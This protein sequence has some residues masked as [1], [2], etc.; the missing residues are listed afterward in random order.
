MKNDNSQKKASKPWLRLAE[1]VLQIVLAFILFLQVNYLSCRRNEAWDLSR[2][3]R[4]TLSPATE[5]VIGQI[6]EPITLVLAFLSS[7]PIYEEVR[8]L[9]AEYDR[10][11]KGQVH[12]ES[13]DLSRS[14]DRM[15]ELES[16]YGVKF[17]GDQ[18]LVL[19]PENRF[20]VLRSEDLLI[21]ETADG[22][23]SQFVGEERVSSSILELIEGRERR[24]AL[25]AGD[26]PSDEL[27]AVAS[28]LIPFIEAQNGRL[29]T[30][31]LEDKQ[32]IPADLD[33]L[34]I[35]GNTTDLTDREAA[36]L[37]QS[38][39]RSQFGV[40]C[41]LDP[42]AT[43]PN[44]DGFLRSVGLG[45]RRDRVLSVVEIPGMA[46][47]KS[48]EVPVVLLPSEAVTK[49]MGAMTTR[50]TGLTRSIN[51]L[52]EDDLLLAENI[53][54]IPLAAASEGFWGETE[55]Q[56]EQLSY[57]PD[58][59]TGAPDLVFVAGA[60]ERGLPGD[61]NLERGASRMV[62]MGNSEVISAESPSQ[63]V[64]ADF[65]VSSMNWVMKRGDGLG[66]PPR[67]RVEFS[68]PLSGA[69]F[70]RLQIWI[71]FVFPAAFLAVAAL[72]LWRRRR[73]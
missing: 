1:V 4:F 41:A 36:L 37:E 64:A 5:Q 51:V 73:W 61:A 63:Q 71:L 15:L 27:A 20:K 28:R 8:A 6:G 32:R 67:S 55:Y 68:L 69:D 14:R 39:I 56:E 34:L 66:L 65:F 9:A 29:E 42:G 30:L 25:L 33:C 17:N 58:R 35:L 24:I 3:Q 43:T 50:F 60:V 10:L 38:W 70:G 21:S 22:R 72:V 53:R 57:N 46:A 31:N 19:G 11:G 49:D 23:I 26:R 54:P 2:D 59:D 52:F 44:L 45:P 48:L 13:L 62:V 12:L 40:V 7:S 18:L 16:L 47:R